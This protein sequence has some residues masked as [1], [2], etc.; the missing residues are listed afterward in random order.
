MLNEGEVKRVFD[1][2]MNIWVIPEIN[3]LRQS[4]EISESFKIR[5]VQI[6]FN[7][8]EPFVIK[9]NE[10]VKIIAEVK[11]KRNIV[12]GEEIKVS[13]IEKVDKFIVDC[14]PNSSHITLFRFI[15]RWIIIFDAIYNKK[16]IREI[17]KTSKDFYESAKNDLKERR[18]VPFYENCWNSAEL[19][20]VCHSLS[21]GR[22][23]KSHG[24][25]VKNFIKWSEL[26]NVKGEHAKAL[27]KLKDLRKLKY[28]SAADFESENP[29][30]FLEIVSEMINES[31][32]LV[33]D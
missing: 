33:K 11:A 26:G 3:R 9:F 28:I 6:I 17:L 7:L 1:Q 13:D 16:K 32:R 27:S 4:G 12:K 8:D 20:A 23:N 29:H 14:P 24:E 18:L 2:V 25:N 30:K 31:E 21:I 10:S 19:A 22:K 5:R 15:D